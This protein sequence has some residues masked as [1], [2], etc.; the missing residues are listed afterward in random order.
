M[1]WLQV[2]EAKQDQLSR[3]HFDEAIRA[4]NLAV[5]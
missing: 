4:S 3:A 2:E 1:K 5:N